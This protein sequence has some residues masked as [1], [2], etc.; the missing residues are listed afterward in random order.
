V[1]DRFPDHDFSQVTPLHLLVHSYA[2]VLDFMALCPIAWTR[3]TP[4]R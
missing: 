3:T 4:D 2:S 1:H